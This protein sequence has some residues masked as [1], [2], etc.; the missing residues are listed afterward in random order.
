MQLTCY[1]MRRLLKEKV[2]DRGDN[3]ELSFRLM[4][5]E[6]PLGIKKERSS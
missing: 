6:M 2:G 1:D 5:L 4:N 3:Q